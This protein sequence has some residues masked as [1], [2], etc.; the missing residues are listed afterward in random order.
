MNESCTELVLN[1]QLLRVL[2]ELA[3]VK[4]LTDNPGS[5]LPR[6]EAALFAVQCWWVAR[7]LCPVV[8]TQPRALG[9]GRGLNGRTE[10]GWL[11]PSWAETT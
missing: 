4:H 1:E 11:L 2:R 7:P 9:S 8:S 5:G 3:Q 10:G 6:A